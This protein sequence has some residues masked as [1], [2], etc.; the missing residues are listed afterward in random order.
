MS[1]PYTQSLSSDPSL[2]S[3]WTLHRLLKSQTSSP[4]LQRNIFPSD[5]NDKLRRPSQ[6]S[7]RGYIIC[8]SL[9]ISRKAPVFSFNSSIWSARIARQKSTQINTKYIL[10]IP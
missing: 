3:R 9:S 1:V 5:I 4:L 7:N 2:Q 10:E 8:P 6:K